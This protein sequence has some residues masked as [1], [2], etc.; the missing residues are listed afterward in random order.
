MYLIK[1]SRHQSPK[2]FLGSNNEIPFL[3]VVEALNEFPF[4]A[5][6]EENS[7]I[8]KYFFSVS[9]PRKFSVKKIIGLSSFRGLSQLK[10]GSVIFSNTNFSKY[11]W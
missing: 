3:F 4:L 9:V 2:S 7:Q 6:N 11:M 1:I 8:L 10:S 5:T